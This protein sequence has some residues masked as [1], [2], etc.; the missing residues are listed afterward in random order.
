VF[1][2][3]LHPFCRTGA[4]LEKV[5]GVASHEVTAALAVENIFMG[6]EGGG[7]GGGALACM[8]TRHGRLG[9]H[10][11]LGAF[12]FFF[13]LHVVVRTWG[14]GIMNYGMCKGAGR[15]SFVLLLLDLVSGNQ[16]N[17]GLGRVEGVV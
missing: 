10:V 14:A 5:S 17:D 13:F 15:V 8:L 6:V 1:Q 9:M 4:T 7:G 2:V 16:R 3:L 12:F 11:F